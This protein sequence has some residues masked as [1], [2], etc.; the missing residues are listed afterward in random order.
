VLVGVKTADR[1]RVPALANVVVVVACPLA[2][3]ATGDP[4]L[5]PPSSNCTAPAVAGVSVAV[6]VTV[7]PVAAGLGDAVSVVV[8][9]LGVGGE[10]VIAYVAPFA[11]M[12]TKVSCTAT[13]APLPPADGKQ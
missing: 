1:F 12:V 2:L 7:W 4:M 9:A 10:L 6:R 11:E 5:V 13:A 3:T 8:V